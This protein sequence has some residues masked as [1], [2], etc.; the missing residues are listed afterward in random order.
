MLWLYQKVFFEK[1]NSA[2]EHHPVLDLNL[3]EV[4][5][6]LPLIVL[7][8]W[9]GFYPDTFLSFMHSSV[10]HLIERVNTG[11]AGENLLTRYIGSY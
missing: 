10:E 2:Y 8:F 11:T 6:L 7:V 1:L 3:R 4:I 5:I 9:I